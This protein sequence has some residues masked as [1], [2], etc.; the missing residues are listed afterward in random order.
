MKT[1]LSKVYKK[2]PNQKISLTAIDD[3]VEASETLT[4]DNTDKIM[5]NDAVISAENFGT[6]LNEA[7][8]FASTL[9]EEYN[10][11]EQWVTVDNRDAIN[12]LLNDFENKADVLGVS[13]RSI[14]EFNDLESQLEDMNDFYDDAYAFLDSYG[15]IRD[16][17]RTILDL[18][19]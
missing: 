10:F 15:F 1:R 9:E 7:K 17:A 14:Q 16:N 2:L 6:A 12:N 19:I 3:L 18:N 4:I 13:P 11:V 5:L 8:K